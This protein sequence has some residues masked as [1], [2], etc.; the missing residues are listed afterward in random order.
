MFSR[1]GS[2]RHARG[3]GGGRNSRSDRPARGSASVPQPSSAAP[4]YGPYDISEAPSGVER[5]D[6]GSLQIPA[7]PDVEIRVQANP[8][9]AVQ[10]VV[11]VNGDNALQVGVFAAPRSEGIW[12]EVRDE[13]RKSLF[14]EG[15]AAE[16]SQGEYGPELRARV[17]T[18]DGL[19]DL[20]FLGIDGPRWMVRGVFQGPAATDPSRAGVLVECLRGLVVDRGHEAKPVREPLPL[21]LPK[22]A[23]EQVHEQQAAPEPAP[24]PAPPAN[25]AGPGSGPRRRPSPRPR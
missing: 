10:Q 7:V 8:D 16:E 17:R 21:R 2:G 18:A 12:D 14:S 25:G 9:G 6:L 1:G 5:L 24:S 11:L 15:V 22:E 23:S 13:I 19:T 20:R 3:E 4:S